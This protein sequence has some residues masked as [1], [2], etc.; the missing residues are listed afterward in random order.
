MSGFD[1]DGARKA[2][3]SDTE[4]T[5]FLAST[6]G[7]DLDGARKA[8]YSDK[9][10]LSRL[11]PEGGFMAAAKQAVGATIKG[12]GQAAADFIPG[13]GQDNPLKRYGQGVVDA[14]P[15]AVHDFED[16][17]DRPWTTVKEATGNAVGSIGGMLG[18]RAVGQGITALSPLT[19]PAAPIVAALG[20]AVAWFGPVAI[21]A[22]PSFGGIRDKQVLNNPRIRS[23]QRPKPW[24]LWGRRLSAPSKP[25]SGRRIGRWAR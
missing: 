19:G 6:A 25:S 12:A 5:G 24:L 16:I 4:I 23:Q 17:A 22:L 13:V 11:A 10:I 1:L 2:G 14:N 3:Y 15:T 18:A 7:F 21:A 8:G 20:Q 9:E